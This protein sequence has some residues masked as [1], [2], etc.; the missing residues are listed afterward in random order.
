M[1]QGARHGSLR[2]RSGGADGV[3]LRQPTGLE[4]KSS[5]MM[6]RLS[7]RE[8]FHQRRCAG[9]DELIAERQLLLAISDVLA[10]DRV[11]VVD[12]VEIHLVELLRSEE[13]RVGKECRS[14]WSP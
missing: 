14:R 6:L 13:R 5:F 12:V 9:L 1:V 4:L 3:H 2:T 8:F 11:Q 10:D 7:R